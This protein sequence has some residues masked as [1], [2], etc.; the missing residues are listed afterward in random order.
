MTEGIVK[1]VESG[2]FFKDGKRVSA[3]QLTEAEKA[4]AKEQHL[5]TDTDGAKNLSESNGSDVNSLLLG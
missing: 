1:I 5:M 3:T 2:E 4:K